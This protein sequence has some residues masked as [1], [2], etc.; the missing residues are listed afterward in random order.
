M[1]TFILIN[2]NIV[3]VLTK[4]PFSIWQYLGLDV[5]TNLPEKTT[6]YLHSVISYLSLITCALNFFVYFPSG[7]YFRQAVIRI[8]KDCFART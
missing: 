5:V 7:R 6:F 4:L 3:F 2:T 1:S 8:F